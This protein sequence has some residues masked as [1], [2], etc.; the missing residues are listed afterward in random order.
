[1][2]KNISLSLSEGDTMILLRALEVARDEASK[3]IEFFEK[4]QARAGKDS[5]IQKL[6]DDLVFLRNNYKR[7]AALVEKAKQ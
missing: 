1:M 7:I 6:K 5:G 2:A 3:G 4:E